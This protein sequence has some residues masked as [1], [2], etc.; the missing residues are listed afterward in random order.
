MHFKKSYYQ[1]YLIKPCGRAE[2]CHGKRRVVEMTAPV[3]ACALSMGNIATMSGTRTFH[4][5]CGGSCCDLGWGHSICSK[6]TLPGPKY[7]KAHDVLW[8]GCFAMARNPCRDPNPC[9]AGRGNSRGRLNQP[10]CT[11]ILY[12]F[13]D[14]AVPFCCTFDCH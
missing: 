10:G 6:S 8:C 11:C 1:N 7:Q 3:G 14:S 5:G 2:Y 13:S 4:T 9:Y 12:S